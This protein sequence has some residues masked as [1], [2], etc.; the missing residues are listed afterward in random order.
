M[1]VVL[2]NLRTLNLAIK[3][4]DVL[5]KISDQLI[6]FIDKEKK[7]IS[8][9]LY[10]NLIFKIQNNHLVSVIKNSSLYVRK[11]KNKKT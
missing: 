3:S 4:G 8:R 7:E 1:W 10:F 6:E 2:K 9:H 11:L 5:K